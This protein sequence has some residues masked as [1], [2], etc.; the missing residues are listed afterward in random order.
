MI[1]DRVQIAV[2]RYKPSDVV[3]LTSNRQLYYSANGGGTWIAIPA[4][5]LRGEI[6]A[7]HWNS[8]A[9]MLYAGIS[10]VGVFRLSLGHKLKSI[11]GE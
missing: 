3:I 2:D 7:F 6:S 10:N 8:A 4:G 11:F 1:S 9:A 5:E